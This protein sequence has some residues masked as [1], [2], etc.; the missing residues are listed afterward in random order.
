[1]TS[2]DLHTPHPVGETLRAMG[3]DYDPAYDYGLVRT[4]NVHYWIADGFEEVGE[5]ADTTVVRKRRSDERLPD[6]PVA[7]P[8]RIPVG[9]LPRIA[10]P[11]ESR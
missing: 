8:P 10:S 5:H 3:F 6:L 4:T 9:N 2:P 11:E 1:M 7:N